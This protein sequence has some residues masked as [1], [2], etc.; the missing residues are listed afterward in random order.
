MPLYIMGL[1][2]GVEETLFKQIGHFTIKINIVN[3]KLHDL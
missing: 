1:C 3:K 2:R